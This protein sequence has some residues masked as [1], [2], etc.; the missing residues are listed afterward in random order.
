MLFWIVQKPLG[1]LHFWFWDDLKTGNI[2]AIG[3]QIL[4]VVIVFF[5]GVLA[6]GNWFFWPFV[7]L[8]IWAFVLISV[9]LY[10][11]IGGFFWLIMENLLPSLAIVLMVIMVL[12]L[13]AR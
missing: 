7:I 6:W 11:L 12:E 9:A 13:L 1:I 2:I 4:S 3:A 10:V 8:S 5:G